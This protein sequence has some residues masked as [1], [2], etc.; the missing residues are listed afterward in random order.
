MFTLRPL[1]VLVLL[2]LLTSSAGCQSS[3]GN[4]FANRGNDLRDIAGVA[5]SVG[6]GFG[7]AVRATAVLQVEASYYYSYKLGTW[8][9][10][11]GLWK[12]V[13]K[14]GGLSPIFW[15]RN[16]ERESIFGDLDDVDDGLIIAPWPDSHFS[17]F[18]SPRQW[19]EMSFSAEQGFWDIGASLHL[20]VAGVHAYV[21]PAELL[22]FLLGVFGIDLMGDDEAGSS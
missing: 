12:H 11:A 13:E 21:N 7:V 15:V 6:P 10:G 1:R 4:Y 17:G 3:I 14:A 19:Q 5:V 18:M 9:R 2:V 8:R 22:D 20:L 16:V